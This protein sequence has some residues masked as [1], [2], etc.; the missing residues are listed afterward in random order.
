MAGM[1]AEKLV[2]LL[3]ERNSGYGIGNVNDRLR[4]HYGDRYRIDFDSRPDAY[5]TVTIALP[6]TLDAPARQP[7]S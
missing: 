5:T 3:T 4:L 7:G 6:L 1:D 2:S